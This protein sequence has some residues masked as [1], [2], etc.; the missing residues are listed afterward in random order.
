MYIYIYVI[1]KTEQSFGYYKFILASNSI[2]ET[3]SSDSHHT[4]ERKI[5][6]F[7]Q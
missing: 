4:M 2:K 3:A 7:F 6:I 5:S 1:E